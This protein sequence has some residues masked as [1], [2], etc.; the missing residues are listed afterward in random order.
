LLGYSLC[1][2]GYWLWLL[3]YWLCLVRNFSAGSYLSFNDR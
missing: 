2:L 3:G 1:Q